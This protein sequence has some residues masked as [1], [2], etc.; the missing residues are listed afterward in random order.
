MIV[1][2]ATSSYDCDFK[3]WVTESEYDADV[4]VF[5]LDNKYD[6]NIEKPEFWNYA[7]SEYDENV[8]KVYFAEN[9]YGKFLFLFILLDTDVK[10]FYALSKYE[11]SVKTSDEKILSI[12]NK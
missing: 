6:E 10:I 1:W 8:K 5:I 2:K 4:I 11:A 12:L 7:D 3:V 9:E